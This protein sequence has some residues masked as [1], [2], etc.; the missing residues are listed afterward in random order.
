MRRVSI[1]TELAARAS[2]LLCDEPT[3]ALDAVNTRLVVATLRALANSG[4]LVLASIHQPRLSAYDMFDKLLLLRKGE[5]A[6]GGHAGHGAVSYFASLGYSLPARANPADF[7]I[8]LCF[9]FVA[10]SASPPVRPSHLA[11][12]WRARY[13]ALEKQAAEAAPCSGET[14]GYDAFERYWAT[15]PSLATI[16]LAAARRT[17][18]RSSSTWVDLLAE[19][20]AMPIP[21]SQLPSAVEQFGLC[22]ARCLLKRL[23]LRRRYGLQLVSML[24]LSLIAGA[25]LGP[26]VP[27]DTASTSTGSDPAPSGF[28][29]LDPRR[30]GSGCPCC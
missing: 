25:I 21:P 17:Y 20:R 19:I 1:G 23:R 8:E 11:A 7:F 26:G 18:E 15:H 30:V 13:K 5:L 10:S 6:Y 22:F 4:M 24:L 29:S 3:S 16:D 27:T 2:I 14:V 28:G 12:L 9:G